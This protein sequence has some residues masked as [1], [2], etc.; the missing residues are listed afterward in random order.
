MTA[1][2]PSPLR[3]GRVR[4]RLGRQLLDYFTDRPY[5][6][7]VSAWILPGIGRLVERML[8]EIPG[9]HLEMSEVLP[10]VDG[11]VDRFVPPLPRPTRAVLTAPVRLASRIRRFAPAEWTRDPRFDRFEQ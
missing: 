8:A 6:L 10:E 3:L 4:R 9:L 1:L 11:V 5:P 2:P 7:D